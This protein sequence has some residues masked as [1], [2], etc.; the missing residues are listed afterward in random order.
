MHIPEWITENWEKIKHKIVIWRTI[1]QSLPSIENS[2]RKMRYE[3]MKIVR[4]SPMEEN[5]A[6]NLG[7]D[8][9]IR[10]YKDEKELTGWTGH[11]KR[12][13]NITQSLKSRRG[14]C[15]YDHIMQIMNGFPGLIY[16]SGND[17]LG[18]YNGGQLPY[19]LLKGAL[20]DNRCFVY[21]GTWPA[22]YTLSFIEAMMTGIPMVCI[23]RKLAEQVEGISQQDKWNFYEIERIIQNGKNGF[24][25]DDIQ[26][27]RDDIDKLLQDE[28]LAKR[29]STEGRKTAIQLFGKEQIKE[30]W[31]RL[32]LNLVK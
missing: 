30:N 31:Q 32:L 20:R 10:F 9:L 24:I 22:S 8:A 15:H 27:L 11:E 18:P 12:V 26:E 2:I 7:S 21:A 5:I 17:D 13:I 3:G 19:D 16:G 29:I 4:Y 25:S 1:G 28:E 14:P 6:G 23:G